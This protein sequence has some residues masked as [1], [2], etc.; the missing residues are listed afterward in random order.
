ME[1]DGA[2]LERL[3]VME[4]TIDGGEVREEELIRHGSLQAEVLVGGMVGR[5]RRGGGEGERGGKEESTMYI[6]CR[7]YN[8]CQI[9]C[10]IGSCYTIAPFLKNYFGFTS[11]LLFLLQHSQREA[12]C[13]GPAQG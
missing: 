6:K 10:V 1:G 13:G 2:W 5:D 12:E 9:V 3:D 4:G 7:L 11:I 8:Y